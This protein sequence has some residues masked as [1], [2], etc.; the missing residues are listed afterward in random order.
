MTSLPVDRQH[1]AIQAAADPQESN[2]ITTIEEASFVSDGGSEWQRDGADISQ[3]GIGAK[4]FIQRNPQCIEH[5][6]PMS[7][8]HL[9]T[10]DFVDLIGRESDVAEE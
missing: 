9:M 3:V 1:Q 7:F 6:I 10:D 8:S 5:L 4:V 2:P